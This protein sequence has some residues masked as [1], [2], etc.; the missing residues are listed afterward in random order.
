MPKIIN[1]RRAAAE[2]SS[3]HPAVLR[4]QG[5]A[6]VMSELNGMNLRSHD[7]M[8]RALWILDLT[9]HCI[10]VILSDFRD[11]PSIGRLIERAGDLTDSVECVRRMV[12]HLGLS[13]SSATVLHH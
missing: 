4:L 7:D 13:P 8:K 6:T 12:H 10:K 11:D 9:N 2:Q 3:L 5:L 1:F